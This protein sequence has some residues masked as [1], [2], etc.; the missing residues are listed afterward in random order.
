IPTIR[1]SPSYEKLEYDAEVPPN[2]INSKVGVGTNENAGTDLVELIGKKVFDF[3]KP[4][5]LIKYILKFDNQG[6]G[7]YLDFFSGSG[8]LAQAIFELNLEDSGN[9]KFICVQLPEPIKVKPSDKE[10][11]KKVKQ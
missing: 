6:N 11:Q 4:V 9:R 1:F 5:S 10:E 7:I 3:P 8:T 2:L